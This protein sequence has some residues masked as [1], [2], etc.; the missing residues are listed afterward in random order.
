LE[1]AEAASF[2]I[3]GSFCALPA[4]SFSALFFLCQQK[5]LIYNYRP[6]S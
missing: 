6:F 5:T 1:A 2:F 4:N 3:S